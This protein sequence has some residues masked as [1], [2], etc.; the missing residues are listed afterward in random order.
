MTRRASKAPGVYAMSITP[1]NRDGAL[2]EQALREHLRYLAAGGVGVYLASFGTGEGR[3]MTSEEIRRVYEIG[4]EE[5]KGKTP[6][7][8]AGLG[9][10]DTRTVIE[11]ANDATAA[12]VDAVY[13]Y[14]PRPGP[15]TN[16][17]TAQE[18]ERFFTD[19]LDAVRAP[20]W[21]ANNTVVTG[22]ELPLDLVT[23][24]TRR[25]KDKIIGICNAHA[26]IGYTARLIEAAGPEMP[27]YV[28]MMPHLPATLALGGR[29]AIAPD[30]NV[31]PRLCASL[32]EAFRAGQAKRAMDAFGRVL[33]LGTVLATFRNPRA[34]KAALN[35][36][37]LPG[38]YPRRPYLPVGGAGVKEIA[39]VLD[40]LEIRKT[41]GIG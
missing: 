32:Y 15:E 11:R 33:R 36:M 31:A 39:R 29:G 2:D 7:Y 23:R 12:G 16:R 35:I 10:T 6:V 8:A 34:Q 38:G 41:E 17:P 27:V 3:L 24:I 21:L 1:F 40:E 19:V 25:H 13:L 20:I 4:V 14:G 9:L 30:P 26:D 22:Y 18:I 28:A 5:L 37:G